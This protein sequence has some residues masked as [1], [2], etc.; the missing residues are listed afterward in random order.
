MRVDIDPYWKNITNWY[1]DNGG[2]DT[3]GMSIWDM[4]RRDYGADVVRRASPQFIVVFPDE[5]MFTAFLL[6]WS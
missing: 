1:Y 2:Y 4:L 3:V 5:K 6:R